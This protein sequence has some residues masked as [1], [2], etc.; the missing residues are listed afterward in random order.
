MKT[1]KVKRRWSCYI[2]EATNRNKAKYAA[3]KKYCRKTRRPKSFF[4]WVV[5][6]T[7]VTIV[8]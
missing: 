2:V 3:Y 1:Y 4:P 8:D 6:V 7:K 5:G